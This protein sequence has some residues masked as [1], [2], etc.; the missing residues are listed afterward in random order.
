ML[1]FSFG[2]EITGVRRY[3]KFLLIKRH[4]PS[5]IPHTKPEIPANSLLF[6]TEDDDI[7]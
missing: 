1:F 6:I 4:H 5:T 3:E 2:E 7:Q